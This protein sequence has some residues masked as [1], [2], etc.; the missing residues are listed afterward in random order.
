MID[1]IHRL[2]T[3]TR[4]RVALAVVFLSLPLAT[5]PARAQTA[6]PPIKPAKPYVYVARAHLVEV[7]KAYVTRGTAPMPGAGVRAFEDTGT[8]SSGTERFEIRWYANPPG[9]P[10]GVVVMLESI[11][12]NS[13]TIKNHMVRLN[14]KSE[15][16][17]RSVIEIPPDEVQLAG[18][19][20]KWRVRVIWRGRLLASQASDNWDG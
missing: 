9:I 4:R 1:C 15:G 16:H 6:T 12:E 13:A 11:Q 7:E 3:A 18:R 14:A 19:V 2:G 17:I 5:S 10:P 20:L 8:E